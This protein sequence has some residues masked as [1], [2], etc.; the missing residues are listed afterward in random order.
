MSKQTN[1]SDFDYETVVFAGGGNRCFWQ[2]GFWDVLQQR[3]SLP[4]KRMLGV[5]AGAIM[6]CNAQAG[7]ADRF[8][9]MAKKNFDANQYNIN[10]RKLLNGT[11]PFPHFEILRNT[12]I[13]SYDE[14][15]FT[16]LKLGS[17]VQVLCTALPKSL[18]SIPQ[19][20]I[21]QIIYYA[22]KLTTNK[23]HPNWSTKLRVKPHWKSSYQCRN[24]KE[25]YSLLLAS[26]SIPPVFPMTTYD[27]KI[28]VDG[29]FIDNV[30]T[31]WEHEELGKT[32]VLLTRR[33]ELLPQIENRI[34]V[35]PS[36]SLPAN[37]LNCTSGSELQQTYDIGRLD[38]LAFIMK[39]MQ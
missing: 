35:Q 10:W 15:A 25:L 39:T 30:P 9:S 14:C 33:Y 26:C 8:L 38:A 4:P 27:D 21:A 12:L 17:E 22:N 29:G 1:N 3:Q 37:S 2:S 34:Y 20:F 28:L 13:D 6:A 36:Q 16:Q 24:F 32:I 5:S 11:R 7:I 19:L 23:L 31:C 18:L